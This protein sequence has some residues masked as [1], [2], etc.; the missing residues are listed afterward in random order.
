[1]IKIAVEHPYK[2]VRSALKKK[3]Y[4]TEMVKQITDTNYDVFVVRNQ[5]MFTGSDIEGSLVE[6]RGRTVDEIIDEVEER[7]QRAGKIAGNANA[8]KSSSGG[9]F[10]KGV[11]TGAIVGATAALLFT[12]KSGKEMQHVLNEQAANGNSNG[13]QTGKLNQVKEKAAE[14]AEQAK[15]K[16]T[17]ITNQVKEQTTDPKEQN[18]NKRSEGQEETEKKKN[19]KNT[20]S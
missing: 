19:E 13:D 8:S 3:G 6:T 14:L 7:L 15:E 1:M 2:D 11:V 9:S 12:P 4:Q 10:T 18:E 17:D 20:Q 5:S 16:A